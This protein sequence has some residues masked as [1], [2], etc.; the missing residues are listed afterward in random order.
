[1]PNLFL[2]LKIEGK[3]SYIQKAPESGL[4]TKE[5]AYGSKRKQRVQKQYVCRPIL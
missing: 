1:M 5:G 2:I 4:R 3:D